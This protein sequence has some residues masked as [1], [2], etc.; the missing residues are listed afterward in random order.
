MVV[1]VDWIGVSGCVWEL[2]DG[3]GCI[4]MLYMI[5]GVVLM[6]VY[7]CEWMIIRLNGIESIEAFV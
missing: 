2:K 3:L 4:G 5:K 1:C 7:F 6:G